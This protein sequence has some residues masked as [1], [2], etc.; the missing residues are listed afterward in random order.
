MAAFNFPNSPSTNDIH[1]ENG[2]SWKWNGTVWKKVASPDTIAK[3]NSKVQ[4]VDAG[5]GGYVTAETDGT[6][7]LRIQNSGAI[8]TGILTATSFKGDGSALTGITDNVV[9]I[10]N[11]ANNRII[12]GSAS[13]NTLD[14]ETS[15]TYDGTNLD[16]ADDKKIRLGA[17]QDLQIWHDAGAGCNIRSTGTKL[18]IRNDSLQ[19]QASNAEKYLVGTINGAVDLY[20]NNIK[21]FATLSDGIHVLGPEGGA[22]LIKLSADEADDNADSWLFQANTDGTLDIKNVAD[23]SWDVN[24]KCAGDGQVELYHNDAKKLETTSSGVTVTG[25]VT[26]TGLIKTD[27]A[28]EGLHNTATNAYFFSHGSNEHRLYHAANAQVKLSFRGSGDVLRGAISADANGMHILTAGGSEQKGVR[29]VTD[30][31]TDL[32]HS[33]NKK[34]ET[35]S[36]GA[37]VTGQL[38]VDNSSTNYPIKV[39]GSAAAKIILTGAN[40][41]YIQ[42]QEGGTNKAYAFWDHN[43]NWFDLRNEETN[44]RIYIGTSVDLYY[45]TSKKLETTTSGIDVTGSVQCDGINLESGE[46]NMT[47]NGAK[48]LDFF[49][50]ANSNSV[51]FRHH[52]P[53]GNGFETFATFVANGA[54]TISHNGVSR[55]IT[56][57]SGA[58][59]NGDL[60]VNT[61]TNRGGKFEVFDGALVLSKTG[62]STKNWRFLNNNIAAGNLGLQV[63]TATDGTSY[64]HRIEINHQGNVCL[65][66]PAINPTH[67]L[68]LLDNESAQSG[69]SGGATDVLCIKNTATSSR[70]TANIVMAPSAS[71]NSVRLGAWASNSSGKGDFFVA[72]NDGSNW[73]EHFRVTN[74]GKI[75]MLNNTDQGTSYEDNWDG[76]HGQNT[77][78][79]FINYKHYVGYNQYCWYK[80]TAYGGSS[81]RPQAM[82]IKCMW[83][84]GHASG[85]AYGH[86]AIR[87]RTSHSH[88]RVEIYRAIRYEMSNSNGSYYGWSSTPEL[89]AYNCNSTGS[90]AGLYLRVQGH[91]DHNGSSFDMNTMQSFHIL[92]FDNQFQDLHHGKFEFVGNSTPSDVGSG[93]SWSAPSH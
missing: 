39:S 47:G 48:Y 58:R 43:N 3:A 88:N 72:T 30:G 73:R 14:A 78:Q 5:T 11:N 83:S 16:F 85:S 10:N 17:S 34:F 26:A 80:W 77:F 82:D 49:T 54:G 50:L 92:V 32:Y 29:C 70:G 59:V 24:I 2:I 45:G 42:W 65:G 19:L 13:A 75:V 21:T 46:F 36:T 81:S 7:R 91:G 69:F 35:T 60:L 31:T 52:N 27:T 12:T 20:H 93:P 84:T 23:G 41:P 64:A 63:S 28:G 25:N 68:L 37:K 67:R 18:E 33:G 56:T 38:E 71:T 61:T 9:T 8:V 6:Q 87:T 53:S 51:T 74:A 79:S 90:S 57:S 62:S 4:V 55:L 66:N 40:N 22:G 86:F 15:L 44:S 1:T 76:S 89:M